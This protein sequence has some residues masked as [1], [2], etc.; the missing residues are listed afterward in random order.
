MSMRK[1]MKPPLEKTITNRILKFLNALPMCRAKKFWSS[2][3]AQEV[4]IY[5]CYRGRAFFFEV[6][7]DRSHKPTQTQQIMIDEWLSVGAVAGVVY[8]VDGVKK[9][10]DIF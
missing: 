5:G 6:K 2:Q 8:D 7:R 9:L 3:F 10:L 1:Y 4:D